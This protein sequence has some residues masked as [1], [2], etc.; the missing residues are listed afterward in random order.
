VGLRQIRFGNK[1][2]HSMGIASPRIPLVTRDWKTIKLRWNE[3]LVGF[4]GDSK[5]RN[6]ALI[7]VKHWV[8]TCSMTLYYFFKHFANFNSSSNSHTRRLPNILH[9][10][11]AALSLIY[12]IQISSL[13]QSTIKLL[14]ETKLPR[15]FHMLHIRSK[16]EACHEYWSRYHL[17]YF[18]QKPF[19][20]SDVGFLLL[21]S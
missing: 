4:T 19:Y 7:V 14:E 16:Q 6:F 21:E 3:T 9:T 8:F 15:D 12:Q 13:W 17:F 10:Y 11:S 18:E 20:F 5:M 1:H 2:N